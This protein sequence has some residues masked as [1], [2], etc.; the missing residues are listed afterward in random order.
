MEAATPGDVGPNPF[1]IVEAISTAS[2]LMLPVGMVTR[3]Q[4]SKWPSLK[5]YISIEDIETDSKGA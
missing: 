4:G 2:I 3:N 5:Q 1:F